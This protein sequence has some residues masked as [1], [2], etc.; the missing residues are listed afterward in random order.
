[1]S[2]RPNNY[3]ACRCGSRPAPT[4]IIATCVYPGVSAAE[5]IESAALTTKK[6]CARLFLVRHGEP[7]QHSDRIFLGQKDV[8]L[9]DRGRRQAAAA[10]EELA[11]FDCCTDRV[12]S[13][14]L[15]RAR[16]TAEIIS[17]RLGDVPIVDVAAFRELNMGE[18]DGELIENIRQRFPDEYK[19]RGNDILNYRVLGG[20]NFKDLHR[21]VIRAFNC[22]LLE[23]FLPTQREDV[24]SD[25]V[26]VSHLGVIHALIAELTRE[27]MN[28]VIQR[29]WPTGTVV[30]LHLK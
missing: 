4:G 13:S 21:R 3:N 6:T 22:I 7:Q 25:L 9:S 12:Y 19:N 14:D 29:R 10:G 27:D 2:T 24:G 5:S 28:A 17:A 8:P 20:E 1:M 23:E 26:I 16:E 30:H 15:L 11:R 18:W